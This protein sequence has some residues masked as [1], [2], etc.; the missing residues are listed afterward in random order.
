MLE[1]NDPFGKTKRG[2]YPVGQ[3]L[4]CCSTWFCG[5]RN[6]R[7]QEKGGVTDEDEEE[8]AVKELRRNNSVDFHTNGRL[9]HGFSKSKRIDYFCTT[10][11]HRA[12][13]R[14]A[15]GAAAGDESDGAGSGC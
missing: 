12:H 6:G 14:A 10:P 15:V 13:P 5:F 7:E 9:K 11:K 8:K 3:L 1:G 2:K 4:L